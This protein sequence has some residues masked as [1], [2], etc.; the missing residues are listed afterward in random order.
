MAHLPVSHVSSVDTENPGAARAGHSFECL[1]SS[2]SITALEH[3]SLCDLERH[4]GEN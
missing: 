3:K 1:L 2:Q 4:L